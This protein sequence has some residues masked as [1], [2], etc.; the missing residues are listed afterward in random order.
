M[1]SFALPAMADGIADVF[2]KSIVPGANTTIENVMTE[3]QERRDAERR[4]A[5]AADGTVAQV[6][7]VQQRRLGPKMELPGDR[8]IYM[9]DF[10]MAYPYGN[11]GSYG[12]QGWLM[13]GM[14]ASLGYKFNWSTTLSSRACSSCSTG[15]T[16]STA[17]STPVYLAGFQNPGRLRRSDATATRAAPAPD[18]ISTFAPRTRSASSCSRRCS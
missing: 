17:E 3:E 11:I 13:G 6:P 9:V 4:K 7:P 10:S 2:Q 5:A 16:A 8:L 1:Y 18:A 14:D 12:K 15:P